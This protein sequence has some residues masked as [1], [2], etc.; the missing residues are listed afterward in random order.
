MHVCPVDDCITM[1][2]VDN[3]PHADWTTHA[4]NPLRLTQLE[5]SEKG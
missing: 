2:R 1:E 5:S 3:R 4:N